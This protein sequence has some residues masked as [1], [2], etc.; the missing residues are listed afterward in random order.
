[1][2]PPPPPIPETL[3]SPLASGYYSPHSSLTPPPAAPFVRPPTR[4]PPPSSALLVD[5]RMR[6]CDLVEFVY[7]RRVHG[8]D[9]VE[10]EDEDDDRRTGIREIR[11]DLIRLGVKEEEDEEGEEDGDISVNHG[12]DGG[13]MDSHGGGEG[14]ATL[15]GDERFLIRFEKKVRIEEREIEASPPQTSFDNIDAEELAGIGVPPPPS[16]RTNSGFDQLLGEPPRSD[17]SNA[18]DST[19]LMVWEET[20]LTIET[21]RL[22]I[23]TDTKITERLERLMNRLSAPPVAPAPETSPPPTWEEFLKEQARKEAEQQMREEEA[24]A[25]SGNRPFENWSIQRNF[26]I[27]VG[28]RKKLRASIHFYDA[29]GR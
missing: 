28:A 12:N 16:S 21:A 14:T 15:V 17:S 7:E 29:H 6:D 27:D 13:E 25:A 2:L 5:I 10:S 18:V 8:D 11:F 3:P 22:N 23:E 20:K 9:G 24:I 19:E 4:V 1:M 26:F